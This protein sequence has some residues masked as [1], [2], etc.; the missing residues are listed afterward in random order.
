MYA[1]KPF[2]I[3][4]LCVI[5]G[6]VVFF[7]RGLLMY[8]NLDVRLKNIH[9]ISRFKREIKYYLLTEYLSGGN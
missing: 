7:T 5:F 9:S 6:H 1:M 3:V 4:A 8:N 2:H